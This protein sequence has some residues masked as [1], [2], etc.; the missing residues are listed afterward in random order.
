M[1]EVVVE[2]VHPAVSALR[3]GQGATQSAEDTQKHDESVEEAGH[4]AVHPVAYRWRH[5][6]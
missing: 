6:H 4:V 5:V 3:T 2:E 1:R